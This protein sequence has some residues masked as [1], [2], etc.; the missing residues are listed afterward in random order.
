M[1][2]TI[3]T[4]F[5]QAFGLRHPIA[6]APMDKVSG[7]RLAAAVS[8]A[9]ALGMIGAGYG[10]AD[11][12]AEAFADAGNTPVGVGVITWAVD[13]NPALIDAMLDRAP[14]ALMVSFGDASPVVADA[15][16]RGVPVLWQVQTL[17]QARHALT[18]G[19]DVLVA[20]G[21]EAGGHGMDRGLM[22]LLPAIRDLVG[23]DQIILGAGGIADG[24]GLAAVLMLGGDGAL[25]G[26]RFSASEEAAGPPK[27]KAR[28]ILAGGDDT[29]LGK[30][31][32]AARGLPWPEHF[33]GLVV[34]N[35]FFDLVSGAARRV[36]DADRRRY[37]AAADDDY[38]TRALIA[39]EALDLIG[40]TP[41]AA[42][43]VQRIVRGA[44]DRLQQAPR[45][46][47]QE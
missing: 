3:R 16:A 15:K 5:T 40:D 27:A 41:P 4:R 13:K 9:G 17:T 21:S 28:M 38:D 22:T 34:R 30:V 44:I 37:A 10:D 47:G 6:L 24:R 8:Q 1:T 26:T 32:D 45:F 18:A 25:I 39:G 12:L 35:A 14:R 33:T 2:P 29:V 36:G 11:W 20:Q 7:G 23:E 31:F 43:I 42:E 19:A 46:I